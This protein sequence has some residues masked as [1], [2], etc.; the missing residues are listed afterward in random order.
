MY[1][2]FGVNL[3]TFFVNQTISIYSKKLKILTNTMYLSKFTPKSVMRLTAALQSQTKKKLRKTFTVL[4]L[5][6]L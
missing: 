3:H 2:N 1:G 6:V 5:H 4:N